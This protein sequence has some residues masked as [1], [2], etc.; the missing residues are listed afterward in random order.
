VDNALYA[1]SCDNTTRST[2]D[3]ATT[4]VVAL[5]SIRQQLIDVNG[6]R[7]LKTWVNGVAKADKTTNMP[8]AAQAMRAVSVEL[9]NTAAADKRYIVYVPKFVYLTT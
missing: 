7:T 2:L 6:T 4:L 8:R 1:F 9:E 3:L 5:Y